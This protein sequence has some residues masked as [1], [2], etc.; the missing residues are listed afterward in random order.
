[1]YY[2][3]QEKMILMEAVQDSVELHTFRAENKRETNKSTGS[4][5]YSQTYLIP[6]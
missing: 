6:V 1:M 4:T 5:T 2:Y 3:M